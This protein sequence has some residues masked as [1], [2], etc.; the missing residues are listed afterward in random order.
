MQNANIKRAVTVGASSGIGAELAQKLAREGY[1]LMLLARREDRLKAL[2]DKINADVQEE[3]AGYIVHDATDYEAIPAL[4]KKIVTDMG[5]IVLFVFNSGIIIP[6][7]GDEFSFEKD[8][9]IMGVNIL[10]AMA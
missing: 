5:G 8:I 9:A 7:R 2:C 4:L 1:Q 3:R 6:L 10:G